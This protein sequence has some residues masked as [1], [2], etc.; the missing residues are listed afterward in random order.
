MNEQIRI[1][2]DSK[3]RPVDII[4]L[5]DG[6][7]SIAPK[8]FVINNED[9]IIIYVYFESDS[10]WRRLTSNKTHNYR[11]ELVSDIL[12]KDFFKVRELMK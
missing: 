6:K 2:R 10:R 7:E 3:G 11:V 1:K 8:K 9:K 4:Y 5:L 12:A